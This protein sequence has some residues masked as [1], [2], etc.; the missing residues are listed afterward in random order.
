[1]STQKAQALPVDQ[2]VAA[3]Q[4]NST[5][6]SSPPKKTSGSPTVARPKTPPPKLPTVSSPVNTV[7]AMAVPVRVQL[8]THTYPGINPNCV[9][10]CYPGPI[11]APVNTNKTINSFPFK[12]MHA[13]PGPH[14]SVTP[15][16]T[17]SNVQNYPASSFKTVSSFGT[18]NNVTSYLGQHVNHQ[19]IG[20]FQPI[21]GIQSFNNFS[22]YNGFGCFSQPIGGGQYLP[23][24][25]QLQYAK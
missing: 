25:L 5:A 23:G 24:D 8:S 4:A 9:F 18:F 16:V 22:W 13:Y 19:N 6:Q 1:L 2:V 20:G 15:F 10:S 3:F 17:F 21:H 11:V 14:I 7:S 12:T